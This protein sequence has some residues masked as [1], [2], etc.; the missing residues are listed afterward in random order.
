MK[1]G[2]TL[3]SRLLQECE[4]SESS[5]MSVDKCETAMR[6]YNIEK[7]RVLLSV[8]KMLSDNYLSNNFRM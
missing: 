8:D 7:K 3:S 6:S 5:W 2:D 4:V 1:Y